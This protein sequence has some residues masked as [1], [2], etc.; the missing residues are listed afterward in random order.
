[1]AKRI[2][3]L[4][5]NSSTQPT[6]KIAQQ[7]AKTIRNIK[8][9]LHSYNTTVTRAD[10]GNSVA[11]LPTT[12]YNQK[13][14]DFIQNNNFKT[15]H[16]DPTKAFQSQVRKT[17]HNS[18]ALI[19]QDLCW[20]YTNMNLSAPNIKGLIKVH[21][22]DQPIRPVVNWRNAPAYH[23]ARLFTQKIRQTTPLPNT[24][25]IEHTRELILKLRHTPVSPHYK[26]ASLDMKNLYTNIPVQETRY[27]LLGN[28]EQNGTDPTVTQE[29]M[30]WYDTITN[31]N[32]FTHN[33]STMI[34]QDGLAMGAPSSGLISELFLQHTEHL[35]LTHLKTK[36]KII[37]YF[38]YVDDVL[39]IYDSHHTDIQTIVSEFNIHQNLEFT[40]E[41][42]TDNKLN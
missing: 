42:E 37:E 40:A 41:T 21:K 36:L 23:L 27:I 3:I 15:I 9:K 12:Q 13:L 33:G 8:S 29:L 5:K 19:P 10:K 30:N 24:D 35:H 6:P 4:Q 16:T 2:N 39:L 20:K 26:L 1:V 31:Q 14:Q 25:N 32:Y 11:V 7:E 38:R 17:L 22:H 18:K 28:L 34:Q